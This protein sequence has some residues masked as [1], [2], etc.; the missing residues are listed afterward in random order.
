VKT[1]FD[2]VLLELLRG[3]TELPDEGALLL[4][5]SVEAFRR[6]GEGFSFKDWCGLST[7]TQTAFIDVGNKMRDQAAARVAYYMSQPMEMI[8]TLFGEEAAAKFALENSMEGA[9][10]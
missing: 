5:N 3:E 1:P 8:K 2:Q 7:V 9:T 6:G 10:K 4:Y